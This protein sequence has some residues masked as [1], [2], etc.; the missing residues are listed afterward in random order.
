MSEREDQ[1]ISIVSKICHEAK[2]AQ[3]KLLEAT[4]EQKNQFLLDLAHSIK[5]NKSNLFLANKLDLEIAH[6]KIQNEA[7]IDRL[8]IT[9][10]TILSMSNGLMQI[11]LLYIN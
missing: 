11:A 5:E 9:E 6:Q 3:Y 1:K 7:F 2:N 4:T 10:K 8:K